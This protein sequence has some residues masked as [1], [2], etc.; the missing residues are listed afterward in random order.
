MQDRSRRKF[1][2]PFLDIA[3]S[4]F[5]A[6]SQTR[7]SA[8]RIPGVSEIDDRSISLFVRKWLS[9]G[10]GLKVTEANRYLGEL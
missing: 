2:L 8:G 9:I 6:I 1:S 5:I 10:E 3:F 7:L 4:D